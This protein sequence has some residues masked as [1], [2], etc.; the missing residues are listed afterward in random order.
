MYNSINLN[1]QQQ[2]NGKLQYFHKM[3]YYKVLKN[4]IQG[5][6]IRTLKKIPK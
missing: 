1:I 5:N 6:N 3:E 2:K 4:V